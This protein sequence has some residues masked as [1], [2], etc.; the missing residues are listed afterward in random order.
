MIIRPKHPEQLACALKEKTLVL[1]GMG[2]VGT[3]I[4]EWCDLHG[5]SYYF[6]DKDFMKKGKKETIPPEE[7]MLRFPNAN[8]VIASVVY[9]DEIKNNL[10][11]LGFKQNQILSYKLFMPEEITWPDIENNI[12]WGIMRHR[13]RM[14]FEWMEP[15]INSLADYGAGKM[16]IKD[17]LSSDIIYY[18]IDYHRRTEDTIVCDLNK[19]TYPDISTDVSICCGILEYM[20]EPERLLLNVCK[21]TNIQIIISYWTLDKFPNIEGRRASAYISDL[22]ERQIINT[23][24]SGGYGLIKKAPDPVKYDCTVYSFIKDLRWGSR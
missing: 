1:Y 14:I 21:K 17:Y 9:S 18:P 13:A 20:C 6:T 19:G 16:H 10:K 12:D 3:R 23:M 7:L 8:V 24:Q 15:D 5:V 2:T 11:Q 22:T 4:A